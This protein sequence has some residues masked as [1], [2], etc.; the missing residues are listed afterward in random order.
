MSIGW[1]MD[2]QVGGSV[3]MVWAAGF[4]KGGDRLDACIGMPHE[5]V[6]CYTCSRLTS[7]DRSGGIAIL[8]VNLTVKYCSREH[9]VQGDWHVDTS[10]SRVLA[11]RDAI[12]GIYIIQRYINGAPP[13]CT[14]E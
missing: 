1:H 13:P 10:K 9:F 8:H 14:Y 7:N 11:Q 6:Y 2:L 12:F 4:G 5:L 3:R